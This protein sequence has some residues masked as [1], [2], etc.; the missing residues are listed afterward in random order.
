MPYT[1]TTWVSGVTPADAAVLNN[2]ET[3]YDQAVADVKRKLIPPIVRWTTPG[4]WWFSVANQVVTANRTYYVPI[5]V[6]EATT[7]IRIGI[8]VTTGDGAGGVADLRIFEWSSGVP[9]DLILSAGTV[10]TNAAA[11]KEI[12]IAE[13]LALG[14]YFLAVRFDQ[15]PTCRGPASGSALKH[16]VSGLSLTGDMQN[17]GVILYD[18]AA[19]ADPAG[20]VDGAL[21]SAFAF[22]TL[23]EN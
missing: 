17:G 16:P 19:Y 6:E 14:Y 3:Q 15:A 8:D 5:Y 10:N 7:Y 21:S 4:W 22:I 13:A 11:L 20:A 2:L 18:D 12:V 23:R 9:G 1:P